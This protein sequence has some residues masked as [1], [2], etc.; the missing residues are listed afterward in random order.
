[1]QQHGWPAAVAHQGLDCTGVPHASQH[2]GRRGRTCSGIKQAVAQLFHCLLGSLLAWCANMGVPGLRRVVILHSAQTS[3]PP[4]QLC[5]SAAA[6]MFEYC[7]KLAC[8][9]GISAVASQRLEC[10]GRFLS[11][12]PLR[13]FALLAWCAC[14]RRC[15]PSLLDAAS[16]VLTHVAVHH[17]PSCTLAR[18]VTR[19]CAGCD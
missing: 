15:M 17:Q 6:C 12:L 18:E 11:P 8:V 5:L 2:F 14:S 13:A 9:A 19:V 4:T 10:V 7:R 16:E 3:R 1:M